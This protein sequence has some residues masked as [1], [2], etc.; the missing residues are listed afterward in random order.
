MN[1]F[2]KLTGKQFGKLVAIRPIPKTSKNGTGAKWECLCNCGNIK[3]VYSSHL[4]G[5]HTKSCGCS[6]NE[7]RIL[8][9]LLP[10]G[11]SGLNKLFYDYKQKAKVRKLEFS[12]SKEEF[13][14]IVLQNCY[15]CN[16]PPL[17]EAFGSYDNKNRK[18]RELSKFLYNGIDRLDNNE[19]YTVNNSVACC[20]DHNWMKKDLS[21]SQFLNSIESIYNHRIK[22]NLKN[23]ETY[24]PQSDN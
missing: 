24:G 1:P 13:K 14:N 16:T 9:R 12:L 2:R 18:N 19:G 11:E 4:T 5:G 10:P 21:F 22:L 15:Y 8:K 7:F 17:Q 3:L 6:S 23:K 20:R